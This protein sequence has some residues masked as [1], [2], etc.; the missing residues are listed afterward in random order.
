MGSG[1]RAGCNRR[2]DPSLLFVAYSVNHNTA[3]LQGSIGNLLF[4]E[5]SDLANHFLADPS[6]AAIPVKMR[7]ENPGLSDIEAVRW[8]K[9][10]LNLLDIWAMACTRYER[11][12]LA[13]DQWSAWDEY[14]TELFRSSG[15]KLSRERWE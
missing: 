12:L 7:S 10:R 6:L 4:E 3:A 5:H 8:E 15:E 9:Y 14:F 13:D 1:R 11:G 2:C